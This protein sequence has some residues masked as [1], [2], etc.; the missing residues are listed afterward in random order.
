MA[1]GRADA[2]QVSVAVRHC[3]PHG[4]ARCFFGKACHVFEEIHARKSLFGP[5]L[6]P[7][8][9]GR[10]SGVRSFHQE[11][12]AM[13]L[14]AAQEG[15]IIKLSVPKWVRPPATAVADDAFGVA[16]RLPG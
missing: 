10:P 13:A 14:D 12:C 2:D 8:L 11:N 6:L 16:A 15:P 5:Q 1:I 7:P 3:V 9:F 4:P